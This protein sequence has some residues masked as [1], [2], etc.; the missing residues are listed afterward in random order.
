MRDYGYQKL[1]DHSNIHHL[2]IE[3]VQFLVPNNQQPFFFQIMKVSD[4]LDSGRP[5]AIADL[6]TFLNQWLVNHIKCEDKCD[7]I[8]LYSEIV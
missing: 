1:A 5:T 4:S 3:E 8:L 2:F 6:V 7:R